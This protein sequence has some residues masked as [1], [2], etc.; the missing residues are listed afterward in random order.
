MQLTH[1]HTSQLQ[2]LAR[3]AN[4][5]YIVSGEQKTEW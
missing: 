2:P 5:K 4:V 3:D 1:K